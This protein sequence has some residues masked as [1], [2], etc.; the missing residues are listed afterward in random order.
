MRRQRAMKIITNKSSG[1][2]LSEITINDKM[3]MVEYA[4]KRVGQPR[5][6]WWNIA[7]TEIWDWIGS[8]KRPADWDE[9]LWGAFDNKSDRRMKLLC[10]I[11]KQEIEKQRQKKK[12]K[13]K[14]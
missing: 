8:N 11:A 3:E 2:I 5:N 7:L 6:M 13:E 4:K 12:K 14:K 1:D 10:M 9:P